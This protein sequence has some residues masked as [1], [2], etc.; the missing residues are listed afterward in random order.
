MFQMYTKIEYFH[1]LHLPITQL[2]QYCISNTVSFTVPPIPLSFTKWMIL[3]PAPDAT[4]FQLNSLKREDRYFLKIMNT[5]LISYLK[6]KKS[7]DP[8]LLNLSGK[9]WTAFHPS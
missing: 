8:E 7:I 9:E 6:K 1:K 5:M 3:K 2:Q 4:S